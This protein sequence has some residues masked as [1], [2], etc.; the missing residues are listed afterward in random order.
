KQGRRSGW[1]GPTE[2]AALPEWASDRLPASLHAQIRREVKAL[3]RRGIDVIESR[4]RARMKGPFRLAT[5]PLLDEASLRVLQERFATQ[6]LREPPTPE[7]LRQWLESAVPVWRATLSLDRRHGGLLADMPTVQDGD[8]TDSLVSAMTLL[9]RAHRFR[10]LAAHRQ[11]EYAI[12]AARRALERERD[13]HLHVAVEA[14]CWLQEG[15]VHYRRADYTKS[16]HCVA[17]ALEA[18]HGYGH[19]RVLGRI[20]SLRSLLCRRQGALEESVQDLW[21]AARYS[22]VENDFCNLFSV[23]HNLSCLLSE[24]ADRE[25]DPGRQRELL[26]Q[27]I[28]LCKRSDWYCRR[29]DVGRNS[30][31]SLILLALLYERVGDTARAIE[32]A[33]RACVEAAEKEDWCEALAAH[34]CR[35]RL[36]CAIGDREGAHHIHRQF[37]Q[38][39]P[40]LRLATRAD[41]DYRSAVAEAANDLTSTSSH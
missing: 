34:R 32:E 40:S 5:L 7:A 11:A 29:Y 35:V 4:P 8:G 37:L 13:S 10:D 38:S 33:D 17:A 9:N 25:K 15:W 6:T 36:R 19:L 16:G 24:L 23:Y 2:V 14:W 26:E 27:A 28:A 12:A 3:V 18:L 39:L 31:I 21:T 1:V 30:V 41:E 20:L 22:L